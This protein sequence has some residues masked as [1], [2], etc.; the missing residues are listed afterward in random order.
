MSTL[1]VEVVPVKLEPHPNADTLSIAHIKEWQCIVKTEEFKGVTLG[2]YIPIDSLLPATPEWEWMKEKH[3]RVRTIKL[4]GVLSQGILIPAK[5][6]WVEGQDIGTELGITKY[7]PPE[8]SQFQGDT[9]KSTDGFEKYTD[10]EN[11]KNYPDIIPEGEEVVISEKIHGTNS[12]FGII[13]NEFRVGSHNLCKDPAGDKNVY[14]KVARKLDLEKK[15]RENYPNC[16][17][18]IYGE[19]YGKG[20]QK[21]AYGKPEHELAVFDIKI[22]GRHLNFDEFLVALSKLGLKSVPILKVGAFL[23]AYLDLADGV[24]TAGNGLHAQEGIVIKPVRERFH[25]ELGRVIL[26]RISDRYLLKQVEDK[27][28]H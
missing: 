24:T 5:P 15:L 19:I 27:V 14:S 4:R 6:E 16:N 28:A 9:V 13:N 10:I 18:I 1:K 22:D 2:A 20:I 26:K 21:L 23:T 7:E 17:I 11:W 8:P 25:S 12:R 3:Y